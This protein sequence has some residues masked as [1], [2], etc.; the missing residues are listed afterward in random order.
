MT[1]SHEH[2]HQNHERSFLKCIQGI[3]GL[4]KSSV[5]LTEQCKLE[6]A[7]FAIACKM[8]P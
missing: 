1:N 5:K 2:I 6:K 4:M 3:F 8:V 7:W